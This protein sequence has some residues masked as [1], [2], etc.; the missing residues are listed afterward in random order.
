MGLDRFFCGHWQKADLT[1]PSARAL[2]CRAWLGYFFP[3]EPGVVLASS[4]AEGL[5]WPR[6]FSGVLELT[7]V[8]PGP[9]VPG[10]SPS[11]PDGVA[12]TCFPDCAGTFASVS[13]GSGCRWGRCEAM[14]VSFF[15][16]S[17]CRTWNEA[18][19]LPWVSQTVPGCGRDFAASGL[20]YAAGVSDESLA[21]FLPGQVIG[22]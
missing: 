12:A 16:L 15:Y 10:L 14:S 9:A 20:R 6:L 4:G 18:G 19:A 17:I 1:H 5:R 21:A 8:F 2:G 13:G 3:T 7:A 22:Q 11:G